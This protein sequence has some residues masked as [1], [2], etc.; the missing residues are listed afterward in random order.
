M[1]KT[2]VI[3]LEERSA[4]A[5]LE[6]LLP[7]ILPKDVE[8]KCIPF[9]GK[10]DLEKQLYRKLRY[11]TSPHT[12][13]MV[14]R[15]Q[16]AGDCREIKANLV[17]KCRS[18]GK[19]ETVVRIACH[20][21]E[22]W[23]FGDLNAVESGLNIEKGSLLQYKGKE[24]YRVPDNINSPSTELKKITKDRY[25][26][27]SGSREIGKFLNA[28]RQNNTSTSFGHFLSGINKALDSIPDDIKTSQ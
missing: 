19:P 5:M 10:G 8:L 28:E 2:L 4:Q 20:E 6:G 26:K 23:Y 3:L 13:F 11:W 21:L 17:E 1:T 27:V 12:A 7:R 16:D 14:L 25:T 22:S 24:K 15:D 18:A 9:E